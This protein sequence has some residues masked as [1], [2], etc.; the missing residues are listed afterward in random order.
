MSHR[1]TATED[2]ER[3]LAD[4]W[5]DT[6]P[7]D[8]VRIARGLGIKVVTAH[9]DQD[10][11]GALVKEPQRD[12]TIVLNATD[13]PNRTRFT[14][15]HELGHFVKRTRAPEEYTYVD[16]RASL[17]ATGREPHEVYANQFAAALLMPA[18]HVRRLDAEGLTDLQMALRFDVSLEAM[19]YRLQ[20]LGVR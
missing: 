14:C 9:L 19:Q 18:R 1:A 8:P 10:V 5:D 4:L 16:H 13:S 2:A 12:P 7:V 20:N 15:A 11:S 6:L 3:V 17:A